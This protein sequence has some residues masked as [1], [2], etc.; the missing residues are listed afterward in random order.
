MRCGD[1]MPCHAMPCPCLALR[2]GLLAIAYSAASV[3]VRSIALW[4]SV[5][6]RGNEIR[7]WTRE[8]PLTSCYGPQ[9]MC[10]IHKLDTAT[11]G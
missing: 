7:I 10:L 3:P 9:E 8:S 4:P 11:P 1:R 2:C 6:I 5:V